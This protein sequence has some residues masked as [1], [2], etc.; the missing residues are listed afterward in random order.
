[1]SLSPLRRELGQRLS[2]EADDDSSSVVVVPR[3]CPFDTDVLGLRLGGYNNKNS[4]R[5]REFAG[6]GYCATCC[7]QVALESFNLV[8]NGVTPKDVA[9]VV[10]ALH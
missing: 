4:R 1:M 10:L 6:F 3:T 8:S 2:D 9:A 7:I 5:F